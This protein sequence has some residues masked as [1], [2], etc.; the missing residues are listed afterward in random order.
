MEPMHPWYH[1]SDE[2]I[3]QAGTN[4]YPVN[5]QKIINQKY[6]MISEKN[7][8]IGNISRDNCTNKEMHL[9]IELNPNQM[10]CAEKKGLEKF[11]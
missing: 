5:G 3:K 1:G 9:E 6:S 2:D 7:G 11:F 8:T 10:K 4:K